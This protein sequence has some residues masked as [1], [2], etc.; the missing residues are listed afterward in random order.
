MSFLANIPGPKVAGINIVTGKGS[1]IT[2]PFGVFKDP[3]PPPPPSPQT[4]GQP[5]QGGNAPGAASRAAAAAAGTTPA[6]QPS[7]KPV[8]GLNDDETLGVTGAAG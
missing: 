4:W 2:D 3:P 7:T 5:W 8:T 1:K 6:P